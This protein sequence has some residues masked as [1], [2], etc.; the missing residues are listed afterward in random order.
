MMFLYA[1]QINK[2]TMDLGQSSVRFLLTLTLTNQ[3]D[4]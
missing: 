4:N 2:Q 3:I 1:K